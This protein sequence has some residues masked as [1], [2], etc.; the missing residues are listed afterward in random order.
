MLKFVKSIS[1]DIKNLKD[2]RDYLKEEVARIHATI[3]TLQ[4]KLDT[5]FQ[6]F[7]IRVDQIYR[8][9]GNSAIASHAVTDRPSELHLPTNPEWEKLIFSAKSRY[10]EPGLIVSPIT[11]S[12]MRIDTR[13]AVEKLHYTEVGGGFSEIAIFGPYRQLHAGDYRLELAVE[14]VNEKADL[15]LFLE[16]FTIFE[17]SEIQVAARAIVADD[18]TRLDFNWPIAMADCDVQFRIHQRN[19]GPVR[20]YGIDLGIS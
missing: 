6:F 4:R 9:L 14:A 11:L 20:L 3:G 16:V 7:E 12:G 5:T 13:Y 17:G 1:R 8:N 10:L 19:G 15:S 18:D 2:S